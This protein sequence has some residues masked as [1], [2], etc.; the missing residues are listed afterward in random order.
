MSLL[1]LQF[2]D[3][4]HYIGAHFWNAQ[5]ELA[6]PAYTQ[7]DG[8]R[9]VS[10]DALYRA[11]EDASGRAK[12]RALKLGVAVGA[13]YMYE[14]SFRNEVLSDLYGERGILMGAIQGAFAAQYDV[15]RAKGHSPSEAFNETVEEATQSLYP[16]IAKN[17]MDWM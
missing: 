7:P 4:A 13:G 12:E 1:T 8:S 17:G 2:G 15:L 5:D 16:L 10:H 14:T 6:G 11:G 9:E 3:Y